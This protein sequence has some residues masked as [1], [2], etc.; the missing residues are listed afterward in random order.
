MDE[1]R[2]GNWCPVILKCDVRRVLRSRPGEA[3]F[4]AAG[5]SMVREHTRTGTFPLGRSGFCRCQPVGVVHQPAG[6]DATRRRS[7]R[8]GTPGLG[9]GAAS[10]G[11]PADDIAAR[12]DTWPTKSGAGRTPKLSARLSGKPGPAGCC[13]VRYSRGCTGLAGA[14][15][16]P[17]SVGRNDELP[18]RP[19][20]SVV[21][22]AYTEDR[23]S[24]FKKAVASAE[25][26]TSPPIEIIVCIDHNDELL[27]K[28]EEYVRTGR[29]AEGI[30][31]IVL[32]NKYNGRLGSARNTAVEFASG[33]AIAFL[34]DDAAAAPDW[35]ERLIA[36]YDDERVG[37]VGGAPLPA[38]EGK[39]PRW[40]P[41]E[42]NWVFG[43]AYR[44]LP[45]TREPVKH[46]IGANMSARRSALQEIGGFHS[47]NHDDMDMCHRIAFEGYGVL[48][49]PLAI[50]HHTVPASRTTWHYFWRRCYFVNQGKV[51]AFA[52]MQEAADLGAE[53]A[54]VT[55]TLTSGARAEL[56]LVLRGDLYGF[57]R[58]AATIAGIS[59]AGLGH[60]SG[61]W[62]LYRSRRAP[63]AEL[64]ISQG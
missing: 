27:R 33:E 17:L 50:V 1:G 10:V 54:F 47:D 24:L 52:N 20:V 41:H 55:R 37:A 12:A 28:T 36:P 38:F 2:S 42:F 3:G 31:I 8:A 19:T 57:A 61:K 30:P 44:G 34:D 15:Y 56:R 7:A 25:A 13:A 39:R 40:F 63:A 62:R 49:E 64:R 26:Q 53:L 35:L 51:E 59:L 16:R 43:C 48:Y 22:C 21:I 4:G 29:R 6:V 23:W 18:N 5:P 45:L 60:V 58:V 11:A 9:A 46:L 32:A 14:R